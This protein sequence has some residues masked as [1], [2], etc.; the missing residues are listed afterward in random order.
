MLFE[1]VLGSVFVENRSLQSA[2]LSVVLFGPHCTPW[3]G[4]G[5]DDLCISPMRK[6]RP[7]DALPSS[8]FFFTG[9]SHV[10]HP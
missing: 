9:L 1:A 7:R 6:P 5:R 3:G 2:A 8:G 4:L 10:L